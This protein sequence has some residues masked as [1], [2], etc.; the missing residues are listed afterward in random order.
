MA[1]FFKS[2]LLLVFLGISPVALLGQIGGVSTFQLLDF[3]TSA[4]AAAMGQYHI[5]TRKADAS[6]ALENPA[7]LN[8]QMDQHLALTGNSY[9]G[10]SK[11]GSAVY[12]REGEKGT[13]M[14]GGLQYL[15]YGSFTRA[16]RNGDR[17]G[18]FSAGEANLAAGAARQA[19]RFSVGFRFNLMYGSLESYTAVATAMD[20]GATYQDTAKGVTASLVADN[21]GTMVV[22]YVENQPEPLPL[23][24]QLG[25]SKRFKHAPF[26]ITVL[27]HHLNIPDM[28]QRSSRDGPSIGGLG[29]DNQE[30]TEPSLGDKIF[31]H[32]ILGGELIFS[33]N[34]QLRF[35]YNHQ[36]RKTMA[37]ETNQGLVGFSGG[38]GIGIGKFKVNYGFGSYHLAATTHTLSVSTDL[39]EIFVSK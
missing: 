19:G 38:V 24:V 4:R 22:P 36:L 26:R 15:N 33:E 23:N 21:L 37:I 12:V 3:P 14:M 39:D 2:V 27:A 1:T 13:M 7:L 29:I 11:Y 16:N 31:R 20:F 6:L 18:E 25:V 17:L 10:D 28:T 35:A 34:F 32:F 30:Q 8:Q 5:T 9:V